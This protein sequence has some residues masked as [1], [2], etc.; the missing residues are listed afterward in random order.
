MTDL[1]AGMCD[2]IRTLMECLLG[3]GYPPDDLAAMLLHQIDGHRV[4][5]RSDAAA[6]LSVL[7]DEV[8]DPERRRLRQA[9]RQA[10]SQ[11]GTA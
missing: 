5:G 2:A 9:I 7:R 1:E 8:L 4:A 11:Q 6:F 10:G 3:F